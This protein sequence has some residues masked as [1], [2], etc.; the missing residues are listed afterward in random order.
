VDVVVHIQALTVN[1]D[2][3]N[4]WEGGWGDSDPYVDIGVTGAGFTKWGRAGPQDDVPVGGHADQIES[5]RLIFKNIEPVSGRVI[6]DVRVLDEDNLSS[7]EILLWDEAAMADGEVRDFDAAGASITIE[8]DFV[9]S[10]TAVSAVGVDS[11]RQLAAA[12]VPGIYDA[13]VA[14]DVDETNLPTS[15]TIKEII[16]PGMTFENPAP[17]PVI[18]DLYIDDLRYTVAQWTFTGTEIHDRQ[19]VYEL[20]QPA[21]CPGILFGES[22]SNIGSSTQRGD[23]EVECAV[24]GFAEAPEIAQGAASPNS[25][26]GNHG[27]SAG[28]AAGA[29]TAFVVLMTGA[30]YARR[31]FRSRP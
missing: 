15:L 10:C 1:R 28:I 25:S 21:T 14:V 11:D 26:D 5:R 6:V 2:A 30:W 20:G 17:P 8:V 31:W 16:P 13:A 4:L 24:G 19:I 18:S 23:L 9:T 22:T 12:G 3:D 27:L 29:V 7:D